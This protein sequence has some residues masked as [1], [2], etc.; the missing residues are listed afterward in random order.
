MKQL[1][2]LLL[3]LAIL[4]FC[5]S[6]SAADSPATASVRYEGTGFD[7]PEDAVTCY[8]NGLK[9]LDF[10]QMLSAF[11]WET[12]AAH[13]SAEKQVNR[14]K[15]YSPVLTARMPSFN[16]FMEAANLHS[17]RA[18]ETRLIYN[19]LEAYIMGENY[20]QGFAVSLKDEAEADAYLQQFDNGKVEALAGMSEIIFLTPDQ[21]TDNKFSMETNRESF[22]R[23]TA[24]YGADEVV[25][26]V[27]LAFVG[28]GTVRCMPTVARYG[29]RWYLV[30]VSSFT[31]MILGIDTNHQA[32][33]YTEDAVKNLFRGE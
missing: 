15:A 18:N 12:L 30:S 32:F 33:F 19:A 20:H 14:L 9:N 17:F 7:T 26:V 27:A 29:D 21:V 3:A 5:I 10:E 28:D 8:M 22:Q 16:A 11:A 24:P 2:S 25:N 6:A 23:Q 13:Y 1:A 31:E 4:L